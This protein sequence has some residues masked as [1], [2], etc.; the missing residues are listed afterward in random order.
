V[1]RF[2]FRLRNVLRPSHA[3]PDLARELASHLTLLADELERCGMARAEAVRAARLSLGGVEQTKERHRDARSFR[4]LDETRRDV[5]YALRM[6]QRTPGFTSVAILTLALGIGANTAIFSLVNS[7]L[8]RTLPVAEP[9]RLAIVSGGGSPN[10]AY[11]YPTWEEMRKRADAFGGICAW[12]ATRFDLAQGGERQWVDGLYASGDFFAM[13]GV[14][15]LLGRTFT[16]A[17]DVRGGSSVAVISY[18]FWQRHFGGTANV[19]GTPVV[20]EGVPFAIIGVAPA[21]FFGTEVG[22]AFDVVV[23]ASAATTFI[24]RRS[25]WLMTVMVRLKPGQSLEGATAALRG[26]QPQIREAA[27]PHE[28]PP[29]SQANFLRDALTLVPAATGTSALRQRYERPLLTIFVV[30]ALVLL[31]ACAN[32]ANLLL[33]R[34]TARRHELSVRLALG[35]TEWRLARLL[36]VESLVLSAAGAAAGLIFAAWGSRALVAELSLQF[37]RVVLDLPLDWRVLAFTSAVAIITAVL[38]GTAPAFRATRVAPIDAL[39]EHGRGSIG[40]AHA[41]LSGALVVTQVALSLVLV[42]V[43]GLFVRTF[44]RLEGRPLGFDAERVL[45]LDVD[46]SRTHIDPAD[47][48]PF[49]LRLTQAIAAV[50]GVAQASGSMMTPVSGAFG[51]R[52]LDAPGAPSIPDRERLVAFNFVT[53]GWFAAYGMPLRSG[54]DVD[55]R[56][57]KNAPPVALVNEAF[58]RR[59]FT[60]RPPLGA[61]LTS[62]VPGRRDAPRPKTIVGVVADA[63]F[64]SLRERTPPTMYL[65]LAQWDLSTPFAGGSFSVRAASGS[66]SLLVHGIAT[67]LTAVDR[68]LA[69]SIRPLTDQVN[70]SLAQERLVAILSGLFGALALLLAA[71]GLYGV[72]AYAAGRRRS[73]IGIRMALGAQRSD[74]IGLVLG[75]SVAITAAGIGLGLLG[76]A[77]VTRYIESMLFGVTPL[78]L[79]TFVAVAVLFAGV[80]TLASYVPAQRATRVDPLMALRCE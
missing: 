54:R 38:F 73:E 26:M 21:E 36:L 53:P 17:D 30:V 61:T 2:F 14:P 72:T 11:P 20:I 43:A 23:P 75:Q 57:D 44:V 56:D 55:A 34:A 4:W 13:L 51:F 67:A 37:Y 45:V 22:R 19:V 58:V 42:V 64:R 78:D 32:I 28:L 18:A 10:Q 76:A 65:P 71:V 40:H 15:A 33:A 48:L 1:R 79:T 27:M 7:L 29:R 77:A 69:F 59:Y 50:P 80:S 12:W 8:L 5:Q 24:D 70:A 49:Y 62:P 60:D 47:R 41:R 35:A 25:P 46:V 68:D 3:E 52:L 63:V 66:P 74:I 39:R 9:Q 16:A 6:L 31:I